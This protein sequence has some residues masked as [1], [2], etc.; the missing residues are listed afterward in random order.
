MH[1]ITGSICAAALAGL[2]LTACPA[3]AESAPEDLVS[4]ANAGDDAATSELGAWLYGREDKAA[5]PWLRK[6][7][8]HGDAE[9][10]YVLGMIKRDGELGVAADW[11]GG[12][13]LLQQAALMGSGNAIY[14]LNTCC[15]TPQAYAP[16]AAGVERLRWALRVR[17][18]NGEDTRL[19]A[20][21]AA[22]NKAGY[23]AD[24]AE[25]RVAY[26]EDLKAAEDGDA[27]AAEAVAYRYLTGEGVRPDMASAEKW[28]QAVADDGE[29]YHQLITAR[30]YESGEL[31]DQRRGMA[32]IYYTRAAGSVRA[33]AEAGDRDAQVQL[34]RLYADDRLGAVNTAAQAFQ[35][36]IRAAASGDVEAQ[37]AVGKALLNGHGTT[38][39][40]GAGLDWL[41]RAANN[42]GHRLTGDD[43]ARAVSAYQVDLAKVL[44]ARGEHAQADYWLQLGLDNRGDTDA[45]DHVALQRKLQGKLSDAQKQDNASA[46]RVWHGRYDPPAYALK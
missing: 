11:N 3:L 22:L 28:F 29:Y 2:W 1:N 13:S 36:Y 21:I 20:E 46:V 24:I 27:R 32:V 34:A 33:R 8:A 31:G 16:P 45:A 6:A 42:N 23:G 14:E 10:T 12:M 19:E 15:D 9:A 35:W 44:A 4:R 41:T 38:Q 43:N 37:A 25:W 40:T 17:D 39:D 7:M 26:L 30:H 5:M 18:A